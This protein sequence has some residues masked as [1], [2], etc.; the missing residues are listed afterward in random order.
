MVKYVLDSGMM[1]YQPLLSMHVDLIVWIHIKFINSYKF[2]INIADPDDNIVWVYTVWKC[3]IYRTLGIY[4]EICTR[5]EEWGNIN[6]C[7]QCTWTLWILWL[8]HIDVN[9]VK[10]VLSSQSKN[11]KTK[12]L[13]PCD[14]LMQVKSTAECSL[15]SL[16]QPIKKDK[17]KVLNPCGSLMQVESI[18][19]CSRGSVLQYFWP[20]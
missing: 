9:T 15:W 10:P 16:K 8:I 18:A 2:Q 7:Y 14:S 19:E 17:T 12:V 13:K 1:K 4:G 20:A 11:D 5:F 6:L 3:P